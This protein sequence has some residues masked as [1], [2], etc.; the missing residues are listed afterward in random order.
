[1]AL[2]RE[3]VQIQITDE[4]RISG[5]LELAKLQE[6]LIT[7]HTDGISSVLSLSTRNCYYQ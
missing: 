4:E 1:M 3:V 7:L 2:P 5:V 6:A